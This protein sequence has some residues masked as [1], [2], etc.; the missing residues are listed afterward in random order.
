M[1]G[2]I[3]VYELPGRDVLRVNSTRSTASL[4]ERF[5][6]GKN[7]RVEGKAT[8]AI[9]GW[10]LQSLPLIGPSTTKKKPNPSQA[11]WT[12]SDA[13]ITDL[14]EVDTACAKRSYAN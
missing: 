14:E 4:R 9:R 13:E 8:H 6:F 1:L 11:S 5:S 10:C 7:I 12:P 2:P 3:I